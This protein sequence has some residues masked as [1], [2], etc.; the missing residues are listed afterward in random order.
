MPSGYSNKLSVLWDFTHLDQ[1]LPQQ[2]QVVLISVFG[3]L[4]PA[5]HSQCMIVCCAASSVSSEKSLWRVALGEKKEICH[6]ILFKISCVSTRCVLDLVVE[7]STVCTQ[8]NV[9]TT[10]RRLDSWE[11]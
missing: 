8:A 5:H 9:K 7:I 4:T 1:I 3:L 6:L 10:R 2:R 11:D